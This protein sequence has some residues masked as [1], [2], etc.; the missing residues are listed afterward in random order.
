MGDSSEEER[1]ENEEGLVEH[2][3]Q[4]DR[5]GAAATKNATTPIRLKYNETGET[6]LLFYHESAVTRLSLRNLYP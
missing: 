1:P 6:P 5:R 4:G 2:R 3:N